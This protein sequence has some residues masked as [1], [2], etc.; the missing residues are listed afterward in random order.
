MINHAQPIPS[1]AAAHLHAPAS[2]PLELL[3]ARRL[4]DTLKL[5][6]RTEQAAMAD[7]LIALSD[8]DRR[9]GWEPL[10]HATLVAFILAEL[11]SP[12][13]RPSGGRRRPCPASSASPPARPGRSS[14]SCNR[15]S[16]PPCG[17]WSGC[18]HQFAAPRR[19]S[20]CWPGRATPPPPRRC[21]PRPACRRRPPLPREAQGRPLRP[22]ARHPRC[23]HRAGAGGGARPAAGEASQGAR[24]GEAAKGVG[25]G[26]SVENLRLT[27]AAHNRLAARQAF[28]EKVMGR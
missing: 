9:R 24:A 19:S 8:F 22:L 4:R 7:F 15:L 11:A 10:G 13:P 17:R 25:A 14:P 20:P 12:R 5:L 3:E 6:L 21:Q 23:N 16:R 1:S 26:P 27:C 28:G 18:W 2:R